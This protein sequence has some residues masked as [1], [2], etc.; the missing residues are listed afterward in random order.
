MLESLVDKSLVRRWES[1]RFGML[2]TI[3]EFAA[4][5]LALPH[6]DGILSAGD[7]V[8]PVMRARAVRVR[9]ATYDMSGRSDLAEKEYQHAQALFRAAG[10]EESAA[11]LHNRIAAAAVQQGD[12]ERAAR[13][14]AEAL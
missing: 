4:E 9:G 8:E 10:D 1:G 2:E 14:A 5:R 3:R 13:L 11:H 6:R 7:E 12:I